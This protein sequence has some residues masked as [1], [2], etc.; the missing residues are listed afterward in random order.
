MHG[1]SNLTGEEH[2]KRIFVTG[3]LMLAATF[4]CLADIARPDRPL[5]K[6]ASSVMSQMMIKLDR[7]AR[8]AKLVIPRSQLDQLRAELDAIDDGN[9]AAGF[10]SIQMI[11]SGT[12]ISLAFVFGGLWFVRSGRGF[13]GAGNIAAILTAGAVLAGLATIAIANVGPP[14]EA[15]TINGKMFSQSVH[16]YKFGSGKV[17]LELSDAD[18]IV[19]VVPDPKPSAGSDE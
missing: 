7:D 2:M 6:P 11:V 5:G 16:L 3:L 19:L 15:R 17:R 13:T 4:V 18:Q 1:K 9:S 12:L 10:Q 8:E 14:P